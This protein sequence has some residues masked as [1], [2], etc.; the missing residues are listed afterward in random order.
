MA[1]VL[2]NKNVSQCRNFFVNYRRRFN[3]LDVLEEYEKENSIVSDR[4]ADMW[5]DVTMSEA[6]P[7]MNMNMPSQIYPRIS[8]APGKISCLNVSIV[9]STKEYGI[10][11]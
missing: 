5:D 11:Y 6:E 3:L 10:Q 8:L 2:G 1:E 9:Y 7:F 4:S